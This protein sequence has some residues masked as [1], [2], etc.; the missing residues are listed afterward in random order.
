M[1]LIV[2]LGNPESEYHNTRHNMGFHAINLLAE[3]YKISMNKNKLKG[4]YGKGEIEG[5]KVILLKPQTFMNL[6]GESVR[7]VMDFFQITPQELIV[8]YDDIDVTPGV[9]KIRKK[10]SAGNHNGMK[11]VIAHIGTQEF[12][13][14]RIGIGKPEDKSKMVDYVI[15]KISK[16]TMEE[17]QRGVTRAKDAVIEIIKSDLEIAM[18]KFN[19]K[20]R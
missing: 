18:N 5:E 3:E 11:S 13:R 10:G 2:G 9:I 12:T 1:Y 8:M 19:E 14:I 17:L 7:A 15:G 16:E 4:I 6:S 20:G